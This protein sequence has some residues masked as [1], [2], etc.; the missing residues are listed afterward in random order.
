MS[1]SPATAS[2]AVVMDPPQPRTRPRRESC[3]RSG[4]EQDQLSRTMCARESR[5]EDSKI[6][7]DFRRLSLPA[8]AGNPA[9]RWLHAK[10][11]QLRRAVLQMAPR[12]LGIKVETGTFALQISK[13]RPTSDNC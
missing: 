5:P 10:R 2:V 8:N 3:W 7:L 4:S 11:C 12:T 13:I 1:G 6:V 9:L